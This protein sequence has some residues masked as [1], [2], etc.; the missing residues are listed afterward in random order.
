EK[1]MP[2]CVLIGA[3]TCYLALSRRV[4]LVGARAAG[5]F[6]WQVIAP[7]LARS[8][9]LRILAPTVYNPISANLRELSKRM[10][11]ELFGSAPGGGIQDASG[12]WLNQINSDGQTIINAARSEQQGVRLTGLTVFRFDAEL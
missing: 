2:F 10:E 4:E 7:A 5:V 1:L 8:I 6:A 9:P 3:M 12:F 11:A